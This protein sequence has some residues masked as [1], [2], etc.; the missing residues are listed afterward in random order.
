MGRYIARCFLL[1]IASAALV[2]GL[3]GA[4]DSPEGLPAGYGMK[5]S[6]LVPEF[7]PQWSEADAWELS[8]VSAAAS[9]GPVLAAPGQ[10]ARLVLPR[11]DEAAVFCR[12]VF[13]SG[14]TLPYGA[15]WPQGL[16]ADGTLRLSAGGGY[17]ASLAA[18][19]YNAGLRR[20]GFDLQ[21]FAFEA[22]DRLADAWDLDPAALAVVAAERRF[23]SEHL[24]APDRAAVTVGGLAEALVP[25]SPWGK[26]A[27]PDEAGTAIVELP[28]GRVRRWLGGGY[29][30]CVSVSLLDGAAWTLSGPGGRPSGMRMTKELPEPSL[31]V[32]EASPPW[33]SAMCLTMASPRPVPPSAR[34]RARSTR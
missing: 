33:A 19:F 16:S 32:T 6:V 18:V 11:G 15:A 2:V 10:E 27:V 22:E 28:P 34:L 1:N 30:L 29:E 17:A 7:P 25:D 13:G 9:G 3:L 20:C 24:N 31:L 4:C 14:R 12:A 8:W 21:R 5:I 26:P 23:R